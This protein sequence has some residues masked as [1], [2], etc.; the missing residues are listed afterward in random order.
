MPRLD[1]PNGPLHYAV[2]DP[3]AP[4]VREPETIVFHH[5]VAADLHLWSRWLPTLAPRYRLLRLDMRGYGGSVPRA[6]A[7]EP[8]LGQLCADLEQVVTHAGLT[9]FHLVGESLG[10]TVC[11]DYALRTPQRVIS[12]TLSNAADHGGYLGNVRG[13]RDIVAEHGQAGWAER[14]MDWRFQPGAL[15]EPQWQW[16]HAVHAGCDMQLTLDLADLLLDTDLRGRLPELQPPALLL[17]PDASP[18]VPA[19]LMARM[20]EAIPDSRLQ[21]FADSKHGLPLSHGEACARVLARFLD[22]LE[23]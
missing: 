3:L 1:T 8:D 14:M 7:H 17:C 13:W 15:P 20:H 22:R 19:T 18:F 21:V 23:R 5:G 9:R 6:A 12:L 4:W 11:L 16:F 10:G 2:D